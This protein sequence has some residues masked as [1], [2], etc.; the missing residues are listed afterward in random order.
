[1]HLNVGE[2]RESASREFLVDH[3][4][5]HVTVRIRQTRRIIQGLHRQSS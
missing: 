2:G 1:M 5:Q 3:A 4:R